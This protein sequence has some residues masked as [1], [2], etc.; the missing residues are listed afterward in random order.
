MP[1]VLHIRMQI[2]L[3]CSYMSRQLQVTAAD[4]KYLAFCGFHIYATAGLFEAGSKIYRKYDVY[5]L[6]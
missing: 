5:S 1:A 3:N 4:S 6:L 2:G